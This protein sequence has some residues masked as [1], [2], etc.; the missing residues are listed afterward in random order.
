MSQTSG[1]APTGPHGPA[2]HAPDP[3]VRK[4]PREI[5]AAVLVVAAVFLPWNLYFG[6]GI[7]HSNR[8]VWALLLGVTLLSLGAIAVTLVGPWRITGPRSNPVAVSRLRL[9]LNA[10][11]LLLVSA[12]VIFDVFETLRCGGTVHIPGGIGPGCWLGLAG[13]LL[14]AEPVT[15]IEARYR[16]WLKAAQILG[17]ASMIGAALSTGFNLYWRIRYALQP[18]DLSDFGTQNIAVIDTSITYGVVAL[19]TV[20]VASWWLHRGREDDRLAV[21]ALGAATLIAGAIVWFLPIGREIDA[22]HGIAQNT[23]TAGVGYEGYLVWAAGAAIFAPRLMLGINASTRRAAARSGL[24]LII[25]WGLG[26]V[27][28]RLTDLSVAM[29][30]HFPLSRYDTLTLA[31][32]DVVTVVLAVW[33]RISLAQ[34]AP[35]TR[36]VSSLAGFLF[37]FT[38]ARVIV[39]IALAPRFPTSPHLSPHAVYGNNLAQQIT[40]TFDVVLAGVALCILAAALT[41]SRRR[42]RPHKAPVSRP[43][44]PPGQQRPRILRT[45]AATSRPKLYRASGDSA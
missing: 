40:S 44:A 11:Y 39:G 23:S 20:L 34:E 1:D 9:A 16:G 14:S 22:F 12:F 8:S 3:V 41:V 28:M 45:P 31:T 2:Q 24:L 13:A 19:A 4:H 15:A 36:L 35:A 29:V 30:L 5:A 17:Y 21:T 38:V 32:F 27:V 33:L 37:T 18:A 6:V 42:G 26:S 10:P 43:T 7:P 25:V